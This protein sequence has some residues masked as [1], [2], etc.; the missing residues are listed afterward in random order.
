LAPGLSLG[1]LVF[2]C[3]SVASTVF[4]I[5]EPAPEDPSASQAMAGIQFVDT[6]R[7]PLPIEETLDPDTV[8]AML[9]LDAAGGIDWVA[10]VRE[11]IIDPLPGPPGTEESGGESFGFDYYFGAMETYFPHSAHVEWMDCKSCHPSIYRSRGDSTSMAAINRGE[12]CGV[13][14]GSVAFSVP[15]CERC[16]SKMKMPEGRMTAA[17]ETDLVFQRDTTSDN[18]RNM[19]SLPP[20]I[21]PHWSHRIRYKCSA[22][23]PEPFA[24][25]A[26]AVEVT[27]D[28]IQTGRQCGACHDGTTAFGVMECNRCH[29]ELESEEPESG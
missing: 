2:W 24:M 29:A 15:T 20:S 22:C 12:S 10:A 25:E 19:A 23:H 1:L 5:P 27:M 17:L 13:C 3:C 9:P 11:G 21:F 18:A 7:Q 14:H 4:D 16:H 28:E 8:L 6:V 26:G